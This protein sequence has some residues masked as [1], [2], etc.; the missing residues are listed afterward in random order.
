MPPLVGQY[1][2]GLVLEARNKASK[3]LKQVHRDF[4]AFT[5][6]QQKNISKMRMWS[7]QVGENF[8][9]MRRG[10]LRDLQIVGAGAAMA[11]PL[12]LMGKAAMDSE[13]R[14]ARVKSILVTEMGPEE[15][16]KNMARI[17]EAIF[18]TGRKSMVPID[19]MELAFY[20]LKSA[21]LS[22]EEA[23]GALKA[24]ADLSVAG[25]GTMDDAVKYQTA[26]LNTYG[27]RWGDV[28]TPMEKA[29]KISNITANTIAAFKTTLPELSQALQYT[30]GPANALGVG[31]AELTSTIGALQTA[32]MQ[33][34]LAG[35]ALNAF[36]RSSTRLIS[37]TGK[38]YDGAS[39]SAEEYFQLQNEGAKTVAKSSL[40]TLN[41]IDATGQLKPLP[42]I[43]QEIENRFGLNAETARELAKQGISVSDGMV[44]MGISVKDAGQLQKAFGDEGSRAIMMLLG[45]S[46][47]IREKIKVTEESNNLDKMVAARQESL[48]GKL[49]ITKN[50]FKELAITAGDSIIEGI[51][52]KGIDT[53]ID[54]ITEFIKEHPQFINTMVKLGGAVAGLTIA[55]G[56]LRIAGRAIQ[57]AFG[58][59]P[60]IAKGISGLRGGVLALS[61]ALRAVSIP[62]AITALINEFDKWAHARGVEFAREQV[63]SQLDRIEKERGYIARLKQERELVGLT[64]Y[65][66]IKY[67]QTMG[68]DKYGLPLPM[69][70]STAGAIQQREIELMKNE[71]NLNVDKVVV[72]NRSDRPIPREVAEQILNELNRLQAGQKVLSEQGEM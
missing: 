5:A 32:G 57:F 60:G 42:D 56:G 52:T 9:N 29:R 12:V 51:D 25:I 6:S 13:E 31:F 17:R 59:I 1:G 72:E 38:E 3:V 22:V 11:A 66:Q 18:A 55:F 7:N 8:R 30:V 67:M 53:T 19:Q 34:T 47:A 41:L 48:A 2:L 21:G 33:G 20:D 65:Q 37:D 54:K 16:E 69:A 63:E 50:K 70:T 49:A 40:A 64:P 4:N 58:W 43:L 14:L 46:E 10:M 61:K 26:I 71:Y 44:K 62:A 15:V 45:Q 36:Y 24:T 35:T 39:L 23:M 28:M 68:T 27:K